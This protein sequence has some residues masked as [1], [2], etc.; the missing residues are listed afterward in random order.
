MDQS[1]SLLLHGD[2]RPCDW[3]GSLVVR[4]PDCYVC[5]KNIFIVYYSLVTIVQALL[6]LGADGHV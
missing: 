1:S 3:P 5:I 6:S 4:D 2:A